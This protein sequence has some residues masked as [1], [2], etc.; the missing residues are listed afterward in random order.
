MI[1]D[2]NHLVIFLATAGLTACVPKS[3]ESKI[4]VVNGREI[5]ESEYPAVIQISM[6]LASEPGAM[7]SCTA[8]WVSDRTVLTAAHCI[9]E[10]VSDPA[11]IS[12]KSGSGAGSRPSKVIMHP[13]YKPR[14]GGHD[15]AILQFAENTS[16]V[17]IPMALSQPTPGQDLTII[18]FGKFDHL[19][20]QS[21][22]KKRIG[23]NKVM[24]IGYG[25]IIEFSGRISPGGSVGTGDDVTNSQGDSGG[26]MLVSR[27]VQGVSSSVN[28]NPTPEGKLQGN[29]ESVRAPEIES[30]LKQLAD[31]GVYMIG[32]SKG[33]EG[34]ESNDPS[35]SGSGGGS[36]PAPPPVNPDSSSSDQLPL[37]GPSPSPNP[38]PI[39]SNLLDCNKDYLKIRK[40]GISGIC[41]NRS[42]GFCY[43]YG[44]RDVLYNRGRVTCP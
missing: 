25:G 1:S 9:E 42:S 35:L 39:G 31:S 7:A 41:L 33:T 29:Y 20:G 43:R 34:S 8:T 38:S 11:Q 4:K 44:S 28:V 37:P 27:R 2:K 17:F 19:N 3:V 12:I 13:S 23:T 10:N 15:I 16:K 24:G 22:G 5:S 30:W 18:G 40:G 26:P 6:E 21:G 36:I 32:V 14:G